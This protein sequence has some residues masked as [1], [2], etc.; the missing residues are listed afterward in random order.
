MVY[1]H[2]THERV[3][4]INNLK[5]RQLDLS[6]HLSVEAKARLP[7]PIKSIWKVAQV[8]PGTINMGNGDPH[9]TLYPVCEMNFVVPSISE[10]DPVQAWKAGTGDQQIIASYKD[11]PCALSLRTA[12]AYGAGAGLK[13][14]R[15]ALAELTDRIHAPPKHTVS[16]SLGNADA[17]TKC[18][19]L[20]GDPGDSFLCEEFSFSAMTNAA[21]PLGIKWVPIRMDKDGLIPSDMEKILSTW[22][23]ASQGKRPHVMYTIPCSQNPTGSTLPAERRRQIYDLAHEYDI[24]ILED[25]PYFFLQYDLDIQTTTIESYGYTRAMAD[26]LPRSFLSMD[27]DGRVMRLDSFSKILAPGMRLG[28]VT[29][30]DFFGEKLD[31][32]T[33]SSSQH[34][35]GL[36]QAFISELLGGEGW[37]IDGFMKWVSSLC[38]E[39]ERRRNL[40]MDVFRREVEGL[41]LASAETPKSGM[42]VWIKINVERHPRYRKSEKSDKPGVPITNTAELMN[43]LF[44]KLLDCGLVMMP[45]STFAIVDQ[46]GQV[47][48]DSHITDRVNFFRATFVGTDEVIEDG[49]KIFAHGLEEFFRY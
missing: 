21:L 38:R 47:P 41:G 17:L 9:H 27:Y 28:W 43:D 34:P 37:G 44:R 29:C 1:I 32:L 6:R 42:F 8:K 26:V 39:Y 15:D 40:F 11:E 49:L 33:D 14:V 2:P 5:K 12:L 7:N 30:N 36:G 4:S 18:F 22:N 19:R 23:E 24:I 25:D 20:L 13:H 45:A 3:D 31:M 10:S 46:T 48:T 16:L 35:H